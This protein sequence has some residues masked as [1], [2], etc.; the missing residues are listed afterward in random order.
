MISDSKSHDTAARLESRADSTVGLIMKLF[1]FTLVQTRVPAAEGCILSVSWSLKPFSQTT[2]V[3]KIINYS[4]IAKVVAECLPAATWVRAISKPLSSRSELPEAKSNSK[5]ELATLNYV[6][7]HKRRQNTVHWL[8]L[9]YTIKEV[10]SSRWRD[11]YE[12]RCVWR[13]RYVLY[14][15]V[16]VDLS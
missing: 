1:C 14:L 3:L 4:S 11:R 7:R 16:E 6:N 2:H 9:I 8:E 13:Q 5:P 12:S 15:K 10:W